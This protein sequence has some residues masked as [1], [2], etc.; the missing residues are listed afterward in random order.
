[1]L[2]AVARTVTMDSG[3]QF[4]VRPGEAFHEKMIR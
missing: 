4:T 2:L 1:M 3:E